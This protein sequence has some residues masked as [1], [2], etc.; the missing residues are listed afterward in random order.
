MTGRELAA[1]AANS[2]WKT[3]GAIASHWFPCLGKTDI[4]NGA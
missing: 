2:Q 1:K 3:L 4:V